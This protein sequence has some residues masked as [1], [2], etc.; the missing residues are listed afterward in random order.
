MTAESTDDSFL[1][2]RSIDY[3][4]ETGRMLQSPRQ[5]FLELSSRCN[6]AC[7]HC[8]KDFGTPYGHPEQD[9]SLQT[10]ERLSPWLRDADSINRGSLQ[11]SQRASRLTLWCIMPV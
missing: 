3:D 5:I 10:I 6:L 1:K 9:M 2:Q 7:V 4:A 8:S 11:I